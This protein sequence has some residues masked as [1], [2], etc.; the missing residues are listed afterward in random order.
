MWSELLNEP[1]GKLRGKEEKRRRGQVST[2][3][4]A[5][6]PRFPDFLKKMA[7]E[8]I[9]VLFWKTAHFPENRGFC[10]RIKC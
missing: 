5:A 1:A 6:K 10:S 2:F 8:I 7:I 4:S 9:E 3:D